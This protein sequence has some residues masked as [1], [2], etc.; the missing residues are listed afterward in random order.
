MC[1]LSCYTNV[2]SVDSQCLPSSLGQPDNFSYLLSIPEFILWQAVSTE[3]SRALKEFWQKRVLTNLTWLT[4]ETWTEL[5][6]TKFTQLPKDFCKFAV[7]T[8][9][10]LVNT[11]NCLRINV[12][13][14]GLANEE[15]YY[16]GI[17]N[18]IILSIG[19][20]RLW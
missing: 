1:C 19:S 17:R 5:V 16:F 3:L 20:S 14:A 18:L 6:L 10:L 11:G 12:Y 13:R 8:K 15:F 4:K 2:I 9:L 7:L